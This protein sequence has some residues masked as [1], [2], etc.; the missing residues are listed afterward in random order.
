MGVPF[1]K[2]A[3]SP[4]NDLQRSFY[5]IGHSLW[6][7]IFAMI[8]G[9]VGWG[10]FGATNNRAEEAG[11]GSQPAA[12]GPA[13]WWVVPSLILL[14]GSVLIS[15]ISLACARLAPGLWAGSTY[16]LTWWILGLTALGALF[17][18]GRRREFWLGATFFG[19]GFLLLVFSREPYDAHEPQSNLPTVRFL[20]ALRP[21]LG[22]VLSRIYADTE[23]EAVRNTHILTILERRVPM[24]FPQATS[25]ER[26]LTYLRDATRGPD[27]KP[28]P[29]YVDPIGL[30]EA[31]K[32][33]T[34][35]IKNLDLE[36]VELRTS[37]RLLL[38][39]LELDYVV[40]D[41]LLLITSQETLEFRR[42]SIEEDPYQTAGHCLLALV[43]AA[44]GGLAAP[45][46]CDLARR[47]AG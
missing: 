42:G 43:A 8:G 21:Q 20:E 41:G 30:A 34:S 17:G 6:S 9:L 16:L 47:P 22:N 23:S 15:S 3:G 14:A 19:V 11:A 13:K 4:V 24:P 27:G 12:H 39:Q 40:K 2:N 36:D 46:V 1:D 28:I 7:L 37:L 26:V 32:S 18:R 10:L 5:Q 31:D 35:P 45:L 29:I 25:L 38:K 44:L 33:M